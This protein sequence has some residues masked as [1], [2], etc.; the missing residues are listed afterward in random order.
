MT[1]LSNGSAWGGFSGLVNFVIV[2]RLS[3]AFSTY[4]SAYSITTAMLGDWSGAAA[5]VVAFC[6]NSKVE[7]RVVQDFLQTAVRLFSMLSA[8]ALQELS[9]REYAKVWGLQTIDPGCIDVK[10]L[11]ALDGSRMRVDLCYHWIQQLLVDHQASGVL[12]APAPIVGRCFAELGSGMGK[13]GDAK[14]HATTQF[15][16]CYAQA[17]KWLLII[18]SMLTPLMMVQWSDWVFGAFAFTFLQLF[19][20]W[21]LDMIT[22]ILESPFESSNPNSIDMFVLQRNMNSALLLLLDPVTRA[23]PPTLEKN[24]AVKGVA[25]WHHPNVWVRDFENLQKRDTVHKAALKIEGWQIQDGNSMKKNTP[26]ETAVQVVEADPKRKSTCANCCRCCWGTPRQSEIA[27]CG[28]YITKRFGIIDG[29]LTAV[30]PVGIFSDRFL[31]AVPPTCCQLDGKNNQLQLQTKSG[32]PSTVIIKAIAIQDRHMLHTEA[33]SHWAPGDYQEFSYEY[34]DLVKA[35]YN[36]RQTRDSIPLSKVTKQAEMTADEEIED[37]KAADRKSVGIEEMMTLKSYEVFVTQIVERCGV[38]RTIAEKEWFRRKAMPDKYDHGRDDKGSVTIELDIE[39][40]MESRHNKQKKLEDS[41]ASLDAA[42]SVGIIVDLEAAIDRV[43]NELPVFLEEE[44]D[45]AKAN[46]VAAETLL[47]EWRAL[48]EALQKAFESDDISQLRVTLQ[49]ADKFGLKGE[50]R[51]SA[52]RRLARVELS[53][54]IAS[55]D[56]A[57]LKTAIALATGLGVEEGKEEAQAMLEHMTHEEF[58]VSGAG[59]VASSYTALI[60]GVANVENEV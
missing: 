55:K 11:A 48:D 2:F 40:F 29:D 33:P 47:G 43:T 8:C 22:V 31:V 57:R 32:S 38:D 42:Q 21:A 44:R 19:F 54:A 45:K 59:R 37:A 23:G 35:V 52:A 28:R 15:N 34:T 14:K 56:T 25:T 49:D 58:T 60:P 24:A 4:W 27:V 50:R 41:M 1:F 18:Y 17:T 3:A 30:L 16:F 53:D 6:R 46:I 20:I 9:P 10:S 39:K 51:E 5:S 13:F 7:D 12:A 36:S 26:L